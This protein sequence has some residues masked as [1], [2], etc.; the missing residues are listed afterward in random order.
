MREC[1]GE[2]RGGPFEG[3]GQD[4]CV[5][6]G[7]PAGLRTQS[8][9]PTQPYTPPPRL[10]TDTRTAQMPPLLSH[11][12]PP[13]RHRVQECFVDGQFE[14]TADNLRMISSAAAKKLG[15]LVSRCVEENVKDIMEEVRGRVESCS[16]AVPQRVVVVVMVVVVVVPAV[17]SG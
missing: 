14:P 5:H 9:A 17:M 8:I 12:Y 15:G 11:T 4:A 10:T 7:L 13:H 2:G 6:E 1:V 16:R 3:R